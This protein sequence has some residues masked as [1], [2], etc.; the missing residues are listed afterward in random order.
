MSNQKLKKNAVIQNVD[1]KS[2]YQGFLVFFGRFF[3]MVS[4]LFFSIIGVFPESRQPF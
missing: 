4:P 1:F 3:L 2:L